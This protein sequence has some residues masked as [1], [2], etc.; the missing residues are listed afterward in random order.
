M[1]DVGSPGEFLHPAAKGAAHQV[2]VRIEELPYAP[3]PRGDID[4]FD[5]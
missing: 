2:L 5:R 1:D 3:R 4:E